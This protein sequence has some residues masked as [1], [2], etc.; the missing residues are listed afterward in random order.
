MSI[1]HTIFIG[2]FALTVGDR[3]K[4]VDACELSTDKWEGRELIRPVTVGGHEYERQAWID[5]AGGLIGIYV[6]P[7]EDGGQITPLDIDRRTDEIT[8][9]RSKFHEEL[10]DL[11]KIY[12]QENVTVEWGVVHDIS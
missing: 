5:N 7:R 8:R 2:P 3:A 10:S 11:A 12:G 4:L 9:F 6:D 1:D